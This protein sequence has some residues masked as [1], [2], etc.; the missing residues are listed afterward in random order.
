[1]AAGAVWLALMALHKHNLL[2]VV[3]LAATAFTVFT[4]PKSVMASARNV[5]GG[6]FIGL[7]AGSLFAMIIPDA[8]MGRE[9]LC[10][11]AVGLAMFLMVLTNTEHPPA[12]GTA[13]S[14]AIYGFSIRVVLG[15]VV[16]VGVLT[17]VHWLLRPVLRDLIV[18]AENKRSG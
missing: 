6:H 15:V 4:A 1:M 8:G 17:V 18:D 5:M 3:S 2:V 9:L 10:A 13:L 14:V 7:V 12:A 11:L 16:G